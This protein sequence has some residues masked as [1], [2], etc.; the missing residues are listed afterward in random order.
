ML[1]TKEYLNKVFEVVAITAQLEEIRRI[2]ICYPADR[3]IQERE[4][5][6]CAKR[7]KILKK[8]DKEFKPIELAPIEQYIEIELQYET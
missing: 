8:L 5:K 6:L 4:D 7:D 3:N 2:S 1:T